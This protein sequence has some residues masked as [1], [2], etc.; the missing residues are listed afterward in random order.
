MATLAIEQWLNGMV[1][2]NVPE[3]TIAAILFNNGVES[4]TPVSETSEKERDLCLADLYMWL[5][6]SSTSKSGEY[7]SDGGWQHQKSAKT[8]VDRAGLR[9]RAQELYKKWNSDKAD[10]ESG[11]IVMKNLY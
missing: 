8:V 1:D 6:A 9:A 2:F 10:T 7:E 4:L 3:A 11:R 5:A